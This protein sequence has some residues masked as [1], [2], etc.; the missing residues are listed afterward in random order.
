MRKSKLK[1]YFFTFGNHP[2]RTF[3]RACTQLIPIRVMIYKL[4][5]RMTFS[6]GFVSLVFFSIENSMNAVPAV[7]FLLT[8]LSG[9]LPKIIEIFQS[10]RQK[11]IEA[12]KIFHRYKKIMT[13]KTEGVI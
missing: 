6:L 10:A 5:L 2:K 3:K 1:F 11:N 4:L 7:R 8:I 9:S 12:L 13:V